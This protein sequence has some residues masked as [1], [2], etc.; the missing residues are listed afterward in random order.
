[1]KHICK[2][3]FCFALLCTWVVACD[4]LDEE[5]FEKYAI[6]TRNNFQAWDVTY[7]KN[8]VAN[9]V[10]SVS[11]TST[12]SD[13]MTV[14]VVVDPVL[15]D[16]YNFENFRKDSSQYYQLLPSNCY[17]IVDS[18][19]VIAAHADYSMMP[20]QF[21]LDKID[22]YKSYVLPMRISSTSAHSVG[23]TPYNTLLMS[24]N[25]KNLFSGVYTS[26]LRARVGGEEVSVSDNQVFK[27]ISDSVCF[28]PASYLQVPA[29]KRQYPVNIRIHADNSLSFSTSNAAMDLSFQPPV[30]TN[31]NQRNIA[32]LTVIDAKRS[33]MKLYLDYSYTDKSDPER[34]KRVDV[35]GYVIRE[36]VKN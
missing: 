17:S 3:V 23:L 19:P 24:V 20:I 26:T 4:K 27:T 7:G 16:H 8:S 6:F 22:M 9:V 32:E 30:F 18:K 29:M 14:E 35:W 34:E 25:F 28:L 11:G 10:I 13:A 33:T 12:L 1:M 15:L 21:D 31:K 36:I 5:Q 2:C